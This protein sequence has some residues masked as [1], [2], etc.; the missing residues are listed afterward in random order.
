MGIETRPNEM[1]PEAKGRALMASYHT[2]SVPNDRSSKLAP[3]RAKRLPGETPEPWG[4][5]PA[6]EGDR[7]R[8]FV[9]QKHAARQLHYD[10]RLEIGGTLRSWALPKGIAIAP[11]DKRAAFATEDHPLEYVD[12]EGII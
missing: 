7:P 5:E 1:F 12:F 11:E 2:I 8:L 10:L 3:Y 4:D 6:T 9:I